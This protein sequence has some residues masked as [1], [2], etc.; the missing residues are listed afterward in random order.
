M[1][2]PEITG[3]SSHMNLA[4]AGSGDFHLYV[5]KGICGACL[6][7]NKSERVLFAKVACDFFGDVR[8]VF[9]RHWKEGDAT[10]IFAEP[11]KETRVFFLVGVHQADGINHD[12][13]LLGQRQ[14]LRV[15]FLTGIVP[16]VAYDDKR[17]L[18]PMADL[19]VNEPFVHRII[20]RGSPARS[21]GEDGFRKLFRGRS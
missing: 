4:M 18:V 1:F 9:D 12:L 13:R 7:R 10:R 16:T 5:S 21:D 15:F 19:Q 20:E 17:S 14:H 11:S 6:L 2:R 8:D 3:P